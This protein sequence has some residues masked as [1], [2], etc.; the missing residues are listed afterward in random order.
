MY[1]RQE[2]RWYVSI[3]EHKEIRFLTPAFPGPGAHFG[4][5]A[6]MKCLRCGKSIPDGQ[7]YHAFFSKASCAFDDC[8]AGI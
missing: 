1:G 8:G 2:S 5:V 7:D 6:V 3:G 4:L